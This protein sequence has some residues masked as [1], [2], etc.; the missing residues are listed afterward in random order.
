MKTPRALIVEDAPDLAEIFSLALRAAGY[1][2]TILDN[3]LQAKQ[4]LTHEIPDLLL[5][6]IHLP[7]YSGDRL[8]EEIRH[9]PHFTQTMII[10]VTADT[11]RGEELRDIADFVLHKPISFTQLRD[12]SRRLTEAMPHLQTGS[13]EDWRN[14]E[15]P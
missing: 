1:Q 12:L 9:L 6:D 5:L 3:G 13:L 4:F 2:T 15:R 14:G 8:L 7:H 11:R 10:I